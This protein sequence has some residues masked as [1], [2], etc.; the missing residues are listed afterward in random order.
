MAGSLDELTATAVES[1]HQL[2]RLYEHRA[3]RAKVAPEETFFT[4]LAQGHAAEARKLVASL[5]E[6]EGV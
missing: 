2:Q 5:Q 3:S 6:L 1:H 4:T